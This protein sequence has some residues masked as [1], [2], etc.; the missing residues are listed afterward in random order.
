MLTAKP[1]HKIHIGQDIIIHIIGIEVQDNIER[2]KVKIENLTKN[3]FLKLDIFNEMTSIT[4]DIK[5]SYAKRRGK[6]QYKLCI[7][8]PIDYAVYREKVINNEYLH[9]KTKEIEN[10]QKKN[11]QQKSIKFLLDKQFEEIHKQEKEPFDMNKW[12]QNNLDP[13]HSFSF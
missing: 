9:S 8:A 7:D 3:S 12:I 13:K 4:N 11:E 2:L 10:P 1:F 5:V 6:R